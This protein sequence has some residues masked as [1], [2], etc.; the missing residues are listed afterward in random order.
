VLSTLLVNETLK[1]EI[2]GD[3]ILHFIHIRN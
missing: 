2:K 1:T 3:V